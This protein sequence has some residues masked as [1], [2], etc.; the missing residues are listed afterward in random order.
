MEQA[1]KTAQTPFRKKIL[2]LIT[3]GTWGGAQRYVYDLAT[4]LPKDKFEPIVACGTIG[5]LAN[6]LI[7]A[8][9]AS[10][11]IPSLGRNIAFISDIRSFIGIL[12]I[13]RERKPDVIHLNSSKAALLGALAARMLR[14]PRIIFTA[15]GWP[16]KEDRSILVRAFILFFSWLTAL[17]SDTVIVVSKIDKELGERMWF[18]GKKTRY[19]PI[20]IGPQ[21]LLNRDAA[22]HELRAYNPDVGKPEGSVHVGTIAELT[23]NK[24]IGRGIKAIALLNSASERTYS[25]TIIGDGEERGSLQKLAATLGVEKHVHFTG[26]IPNA[27]LYIETFDVFLL[28]SVKEGMPYVLIESGDAGIPTVTTNVINPDLTEQYKTII[29]V[30]TVLPKEIASAIV[31]AN[32]LLRQGPTS[33]K[34]TL[35]NMQNATVSLY[36]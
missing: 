1:T 13:I 33:S 15:H 9:I 30:S 16:F 21:S 8:G 34:F 3:K 18:V 28:P 5:K 29:Q 22:L 25:Y 6:D 27:S 20:G 12:R 36:A 14:V 23:R 19:V 24:G 17:L 11:E 31:Q 4:N 7:H 32:S 2:Y 10:H 26:F 35:E